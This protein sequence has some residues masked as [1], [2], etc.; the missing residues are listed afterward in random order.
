MLDQPESFVIARKSITTLSKMIF[1]LK[2][3]QK[4]TKDLI[5]DP[6][7]NALTNVALQRYLEMEDGFGSDLSVENLT[8]GL[9]PEELRVGIAQ[10]FCRS[11]A[12]ADVRQAWLLSPPPLVA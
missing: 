9:I 5:H 10:K 3:T 4:T 7:T 12:T 2:V 6:S 11:E 1:P 8:L